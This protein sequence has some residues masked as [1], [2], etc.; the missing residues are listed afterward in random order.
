MGATD[1]TRVLS[2]QPSKFDSVVPPGVPGWQTLQWP[3]DITF[4]HY[5][6]MSLFT[7]VKPKPR[8]PLRP[9]AGAGI[10]SYLNVVEVVSFLRRSGS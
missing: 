2:P 5:H 3:P 10:Q 7:K 4:S 9:R 8:R 6:T 1:T